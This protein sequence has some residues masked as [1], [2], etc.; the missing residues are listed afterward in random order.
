M[1]VMTALLIEVQLLEILLISPVP[2]LT[3]HVKMSAVS[4]RPRAQIS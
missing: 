1:M 4:V 2:F 3:K